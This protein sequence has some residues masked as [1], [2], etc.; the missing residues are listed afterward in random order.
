MFP[1][2]L[3]KNTA[4]GRF[5]PISFRPAPLPGG[6][7]IPRYKSI[8]HHTEGFDSVEAAKEWVTTKVVEGKA[9]DKTTTVVDW[10]G[11]GIPAMVEFF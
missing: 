4:T 10:D 8:G 7:S 11:N 3:L 5:H 6:S 1:T 9:V 2:C